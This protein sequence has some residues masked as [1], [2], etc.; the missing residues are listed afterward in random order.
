MMPGSGFLT[1]EHAMMSTEHRTHTE[2]F[3]LFSLDVPSCSL[4]TS[5]WI[6]KSRHHV[7]ASN[8]HKPKSSPD[9]LVG[10]LWRPD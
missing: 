4:D 7:P 5:L 9:F 6:E 3:G 8:H 1:T 10:G 2:G